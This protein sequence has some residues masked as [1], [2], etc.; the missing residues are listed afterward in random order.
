MSSHQPRPG[1]PPPLG[2]SYG[3]RDL[4]PLA[5]LT[6]PML[7]SL[8]HLRR[9]VVGVEDM[10]GV[11]AHRAIGLLSAF[12][13][14]NPPD[15]A[16]GVELLRI[17]LV[18]EPHFSDDA[19]LARASLAVLIACH[20][21][22]REAEATALLKLWEQHE[23][24]TLV[25]C[26]FLAEH[27]RVHAAHSR[28]VDPAALE[29]RRALLEQRIVSLRVLASDD[30]SVAE[31]IDSCANDHD[32]SQRHRRTRVYRGP[33]GWGLSL[34]AWAKGARELSESSGALWQREGAH[35]FAKDYFPIHRSY[36]LDTGNQP[37]LVAVE[38]TRDF[39]LLSE[40]AR[41][42][43]PAAFVQAFTEALSRWPSLGFDERVIDLSLRVYAVLP[44][45]IEDEQRL[46]QLRA[47]I[48]GAWSAR[49]E[50]S[51]LGLRTRVGIML[52]LHY[53]A[54]ELAA[55]LHELGDADRITAKLVEIERLRDRV[56]YLQAQ[57]NAQWRLWSDGLMPNE[58]RLAD[59]IGGRFEHELALRSTRQFLAPFANTDLAGELRR[60]C[61]ITREA[62][63]SEQADLPARIRLAVIL[64]GLL[65]LAQ[66]VRGVEGLEGAVA[67]RVI[68]L[69]EG[70]YRLFADPADGPP[71]FGLREAIA[72][73]GFACASTPSR[74]RVRVGELA[75]LALAIHRRCVEQRALAEAR[76][77]VVLWDDFDPAAGTVLS[78]GVVAELL[79]AHGLFE[80]EIGL[81]ADREAYL[82]T[83]A[84]R[85][86]T[87]EVWLARRRTCASDTM[88]LAQLLETY[89]N[90]NEAYVRSRRADLRPD[91]R[92]D[93]LRA[94]IEAARRSVA[95][96]SGR[97]HPLRPEYWHAIG[98][99]AYGTTVPK[100]AI[101]E[102][103]EL[104]TT[105]AAKIRETHEHPELVPS[106]A[107]SLRRSF[108]AGASL[109]SPDVTP[110]S[111]KAL[112]LLLSLGNFEIERELCSKSTQFVSR[113][114]GSEP[115]ETIIRLWEQ[116]LQR[117][118]LGPRCIDGLVEMIAERALALHDAGGPDEIVHRLVERVHELEQ[119]AHAQRKL[120]SDYVSGDVLD[121]YQEDM[122]MLEYT[123]RMGRSREPDE[124][125]PSE[126][127]L[128]SLREWA[129][130][131]AD[132]AVE[133]KARGKGDDEDQAEVTIVSIVS[134]K[135]DLPGFLVE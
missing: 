57:F 1:P 27:Y 14:P 11:V 74:E 81:D 102:I 73:L 38:K 121:L 134:P 28:S 133:K 30:M 35:K 131:M 132:K 9:E 46:E 115:A 71:T 52:L 50:Q 18:E 76:E 86:D 4:T 34:E 55:G 60:L 128:S 2:R 127:L 126:E 95:R 99:E 101:I 88:S 10:Q 37:D 110:S 21:R 80:C 15:P 84:E 72:L 26:G 53:R 125:A 83:V 19:E 67:G 129:R 120:W 64:D 118:P 94:R 58:E 92:G 123:R 8:A 36:A 68:A 42:S 108:Q 124:R 113:A 109:W 63:Q 111:A 90:P 48:V 45:D 41:S 44:L 33:H 104:L 32:L 91:A 39:V 40:L 5:H 135:S 103:D 6:E 85:L 17:A 119:I 47:T 107:E 20:E 106:I 69:L 51:P 54:R 97:R 23:P 65:A 87:L 66:E 29:R 16:L 105:W 122:S 31:L 24:S 3:D 7:E 22:G 96:S 100:E 77:L 93:E 56:E 82:L 78:C 117:E 116:R 114:A 59:I 62:L 49:A 12:F 112:E 43:D 79:L 98:P 70:E 75:E 130:D 25:A 13:G 61:A 89:R